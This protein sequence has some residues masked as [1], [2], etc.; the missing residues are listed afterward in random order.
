MN[1]NNAAHTVLIEAILGFYCQVGLLV[2]SRQDL[3]HGHGVVVRAA[4]GVSPHGL[5]GGGT[6]SNWA[7]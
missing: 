4:S 6:L 2:E 3:R 1:S 7:A 5:H